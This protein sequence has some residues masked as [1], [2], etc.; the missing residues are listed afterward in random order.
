MKPCP[1]CGH[2]SWRLSQWSPSLVFCNWCNFVG[3]SMD[4]L[5]DL[6]ATPVRIPIQAGPPPTPAPTTAPLVWSLVRDHLASLDQQA[7]PQA[8]APDPTPD[9]PHLGYLAARR[10]D[11]LAQE[12][13]HGLA[14][15]F[16]NLG[17]PYRASVSQ[18]LR[19]HRRH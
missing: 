17:L 5:G 9:L 10:A 3:Q 15:Q 11:L 1:R 16:L 4:Y 8:Q 19:R 6:D 14:V 12:Q 7:G 18:I 13:D 2:Q